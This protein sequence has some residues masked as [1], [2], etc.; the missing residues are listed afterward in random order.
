MKQIFFT[1]ILLA[2]LVSCDAQKGQIM[3]DVSVEKAAKMIANDQVVIIDVRT[4]EEYEGGH[5]ENSTNLD[6]YDQ[7]FKKELDKLSRDKAYLVYCHAGG[8]SARSQK[9]MEEMGFTEVYN[10]SEGYSAWV[11]AN[12]KTVK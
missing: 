3:E 11:E 8:R 1:V 7:E 2:G 4:Y 5:L 9:I 6:V 10:L 12:E